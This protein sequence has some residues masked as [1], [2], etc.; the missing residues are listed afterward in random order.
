MTQKFNLWYNIFMSIR[1]TSFAPGEFY[2][3]YNRGNDKRDIFHDEQDYFYF[4]KTLNIFNSKMKL[5]LRYISEDF[6]IYNNK[7]DLVSIGGYCLMPNHF[8]LLVSEKE[9]G[10]ISKFM[11]KVLTGYVMYYN[12]KYKRTGSLFEG[13][14]K[15][16]H[17]SND[18][19]FKYLFSY[20]HLNPVK[21]IE[22]KW[23]TEGVKDHKK[24]LDFLY[25]YEYSSYKK[26]LKGEDKYNIIENSIFPDY[27]ATR[28]SF[29]KDIFEWLNYGKE[30]L[31]EKG[32]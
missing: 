25:N 11:Q 22:P 12:Q 21:L 18:R 3:I 13:K 26:Y 27:F 24:A 8:H 29:E 30:D 15:S 5:R 28:G 10:G 20:I 6:L 1:K 23:K 2:H 19:Y 4:L 32:G 16:K 9:S 17:I 14:F 7:L 31:H